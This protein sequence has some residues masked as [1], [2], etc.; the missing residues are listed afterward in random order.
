GFWILDFGFWIGPAL[1]NLAAMNE[2]QFKARTKGLALEV[3]KLVDE[4]PRSRT[5]DILTGQLARAAT[6]VASNYRAAFQN[7]SAFQSGYTA[8]SS[9]PRRIKSWRSRMMV[10]RA[11]PYS[12]AK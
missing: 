12:P 8:A 9:C 3:I 1:S 10:L 7:H 4:L 11:T 5:T 6:S 2:Q